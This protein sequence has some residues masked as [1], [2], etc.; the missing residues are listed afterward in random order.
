MS[1]KFIPYDFNPGLSQV[2]IPKTAEHKVTTF[3]PTVEVR[4]AA[5]Q[6]NPNQTERPS[7]KV[8]LLC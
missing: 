5:H 2:I 7:Q 1:A 8:K 6:K 3:A 4:K